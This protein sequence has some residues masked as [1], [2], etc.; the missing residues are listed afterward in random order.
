MKLLAALPAL[1]FSLP[2]LGSVD[3][4]PW[5][6]AVVAFLVSYLVLWWVRAVVLEALTKR[7]S[8]HR[9]SPLVTLIRGI[10]DI[11]ALVYSLASFYL[12][13]QFFTLPPLPD[14]LF[15]LLILLSVVWQAIRIA[16]SVL[17]SFIATYLRDHADEKGVPDPNDAT[18]SNLIA[19]LAKIALWVLGGLFVLSNLG[20]EVTSLIAGLGIGGIAIAFA[21]QGVLSDLFASLS[22]YLDKP[23]RIGDFI[24]VGNDS[25]I[26]EKIGIKTTRIRTLQ[27]EELVV[28]N[29]ELT[30]ARV[31]NFKKMKE[32]RVN[33]TLGVTY[34][35]PPEKLRRIPEMVREI[36]AA[37]EGARIDRVHFT[38]FADSALLFEIVFHVESPE[39][40][41]YLDIK[42]K[43]N[44]MLL[45]CF[46]AEGIEFAFPTQ[47]V[48]V[49]NN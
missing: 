8:E 43:F 49:K 22:I 10:K 37:L 20:I 15:T 40:A 17:E 21:L 6:L 48:F 25:G 44:L 33:F 4:R 35:T 19:L 11:P 27:G 36:F 31:Q 23:F 41:R 42:E 5:L 24:V 38:T 34:D 18:M 7:L 32:R 9:E 16:T 2:L 3:L 1:E 46:Q 39:F 47:T 26:V 45:E 29:N 28:S 13:A 12:A 30:T 14:K